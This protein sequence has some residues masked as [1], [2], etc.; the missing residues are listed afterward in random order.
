MTKKIKLKATWVSLKRLS[1]IPWYSYSMER[2]V[3]F[4]NNGGESSVALQTKTWYYRYIKHLDKM[5]TLCIVSFWLYFKDWERRSG[6]I[7]PFF[8]L[9][10][11]TFVTNNM[12]YR[13]NRNFFLIKK[14]IGHLIIFHRM[15]VPELYYR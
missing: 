8:F 2:Y 11:A 6:K 1:E 4:K 9:M 14:N 3:A 10:V 15:T 7:L 13:S 5:R 12:N